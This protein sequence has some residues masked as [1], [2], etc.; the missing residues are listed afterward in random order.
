MM[1]WKRCFP[2]L[3]RS[4]SGWSDD[5]S[6]PTL[7]VYAELQLAISYRSTRDLVYFYWVMVTVPFSRS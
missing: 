4:F 2:F 1:A 7:G 5:I 3:L 6:S